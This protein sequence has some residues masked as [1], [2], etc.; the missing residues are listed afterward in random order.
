ML[1]Q[2]IEE[3]ADPHVNTHRMRERLLHRPDLVRPIVTGQRLRQLLDAIEAT[4]SPMVE[5]Y[6][7]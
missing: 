4:L 7:G 5:G 3:P 1:R 6:G 2:I